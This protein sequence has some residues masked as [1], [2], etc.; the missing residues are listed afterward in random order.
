MKITGKIKIIMPTLAFASGFKKRLLVVTTPEQYPQDI[1]IEFLK[2]K[3]DI[4]DKYSPNDEVEVEVNLRG[5]E[6]NGKYYVQ[7]QAWKIN[8]VE[9]FKSNVEQAAKELIEDAPF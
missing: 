5:S 1:A 8:K 6:Y 3:S 4:L 2:E 7:L 9:G